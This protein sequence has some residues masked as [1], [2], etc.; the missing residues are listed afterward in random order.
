MRFTLIFLLS[1][2]ICVVVSAETLEGVDPM[3]NGRYHL[4]RESVGAW[5]VFTPST[6]S[7][8]LA[9]LAKKG[10][11]I[12]STSKVEGITG[13][14]VHDPKNSS[15]SSVEVYDNDKDEI[16]DRIL[17]YQQDGSS[18]FIEARLINGQWIIKKN[19]LEE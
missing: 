18:G 1:T 9:I 14:T 10:K 16:Y 13:V 11:P 12:V 8:R 4:E 6:A 7:E 5:E 17:F 19:V 3:T 2:L 15:L